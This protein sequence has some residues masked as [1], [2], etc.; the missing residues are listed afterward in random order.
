MLIF[1]LF[2]DQISEGKSPKKRYSSMIRG[3]GPEREQKSMTG[4][5]ASLD[6]S[7]KTT[8]LTA[9]NG[10]PYFEFRLKTGES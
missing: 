9:S 10:S 2:S 7:L 3:T 6:Q 5:K 4:R 8:K 1:L